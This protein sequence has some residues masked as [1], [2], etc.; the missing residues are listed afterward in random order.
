MERF[1]AWCDRNDTP[2]FVNT[3]FGCMTKVSHTHSFIPLWQPPFI[4]KLAA[5]D[6][7]HLNGLAMKNGTPRYV[8]AISQSDVA[9]GW[10]D[11]RH[12]GGVALSM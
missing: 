3:L 4:S 11:K 9:D 1:V 7:C 12:N 8:T 2:I 6:R 5:E 10:R